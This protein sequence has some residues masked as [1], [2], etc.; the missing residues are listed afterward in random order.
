MGRIGTDTSKIQAD[1]NDA[2]KRV[3]KGDVSA[4]PEVTRLSASLTRKIPGASEKIRQRRAEIEAAKEK[5]LKIM[6]PGIDSL[7][8]CM[9][10]VP[11]KLW[12]DFLKKAS[13]GE[14]KDVTCLFEA[15]TA[16][17]YSLSGMARRIAELG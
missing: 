1:L 2:M 6:Q 10:K 13:S 16:E 3:A 9:A 17:G 4:L 11:P 8:E 15:L 14:K 7:Q 12:A 5:I